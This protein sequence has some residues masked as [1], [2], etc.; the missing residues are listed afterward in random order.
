MTNGSQEIEELQFLQ[1]YL[2]QEN[3]KI[4]KM[5]DKLFSR[6]NKILERLELEKNLDKSRSI[7]NNQRNKKKNTLIPIH[8]KNQKT[9]N[10]LQQEARDKGFFLSKENI[11]NMG[12]DLLT[13]ET[14]VNGVSVVDLFQEYELE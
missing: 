9:I 3:D 12:L 8:E 7:R 1:N 2:Q 5:K 14:S 11:V 6:Y 10:K 13:K 4:E